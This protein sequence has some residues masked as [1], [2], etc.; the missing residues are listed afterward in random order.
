MKVAGRNQG[1]ADPASQRGVLSNMTER[2][3]ETAAEMS[4]QGGLEMRGLSCGS[5]YV[6]L[7]LFSE[8]GRSQSAGSEDGMRESD[9]RLCATTERITGAGRAQ[10]VPEEKKSYCKCLR[11]N[12]KEHGEVSWPPVTRGRS[13]PAHRKYFQSR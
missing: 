8:A 7:S 11:K 2:G 6:C 10:E 4:A 1:A 5:L 3:P 13:A 9:C 12:W